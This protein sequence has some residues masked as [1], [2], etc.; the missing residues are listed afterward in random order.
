M[1]ADSTGAVT[2]VVAEVASFDG[3]CSHFGDSSS[4]DGFRFGIES[5]PLGDPL[6]VL[7]PETGARTAGRWI[8]VESMFE[9]F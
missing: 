3:S 1:V 2:I 9:T 7:A 8:R 5:F 4:F 6:I